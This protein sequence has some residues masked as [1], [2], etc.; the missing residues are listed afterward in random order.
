MPSIGGQALAE[1]MKGAG[2]APKVIFMSAH[3]DGRLRDLGIATSEPTFL[4]KA[5]SAADLTRRVRA[6][7]DA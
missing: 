3:P 7:L 6:T 4:R 5:F 2:L 1:A